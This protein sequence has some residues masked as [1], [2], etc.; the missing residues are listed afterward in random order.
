MCAQHGILDFIDTRLQEALAAGALE[1][2]TVDTVWNTVKECHAPNYTDWESV[3]P[4]VQCKGCQDSEYPCH[5]LRDV[6]S[7]WMDHPDFDKRW[8]LGYA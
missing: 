8:E 1:P 4:L 2:F 5:R 7:S 3:S 6:A